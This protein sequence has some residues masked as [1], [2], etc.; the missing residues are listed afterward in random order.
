MIGTN[1]TKRKISVKKNPSV[2]MN[3]VQSK[4]V[5]EY[6]AQDDGRKSCCKLVT[7]IT[8][9]SSHIPILTMI[10]M[11]KSQNSLSRKRLNH[12]NW[13]EIPLQKIRNQYNIQFRTSH[14]G[15][16]N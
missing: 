3:I 14:I 9:R 1:L 12:R 8:K 4:I 13:I 2:P 5:G 6:I 15:F 10:E 7:M 11:T 16:L